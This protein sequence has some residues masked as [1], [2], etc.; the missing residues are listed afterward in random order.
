MEPL[1]RA[2]TLQGF[3]AMVTDLGGQPEVILRRVGLDLDVLN[4]VDKWISFQSVLFAY[5]SAALATG[6]LENQTITVSALRLI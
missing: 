4:R 5:E 2:R 6:W 3:G 1:V